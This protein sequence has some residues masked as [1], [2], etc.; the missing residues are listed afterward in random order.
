M[1]D[2]ATF[3]LGVVFTT[4]GMP[5][6]QT[7]GDIVLT[8]SEA[9]KAKIAISITKS[10]KKMSEISSPEGGGYAIGFHYEPSSEEEE[11]EDEEEERLD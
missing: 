11:Y 7:I 6:L 2:I 4:I 10:D 8:F 9:V 3:L 1:K 5:L